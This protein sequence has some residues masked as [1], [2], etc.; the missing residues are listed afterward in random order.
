MK[1]HEIAVKFSDSIISGLI[2]SAKHMLWPLSVNRIRQSQ[3][4]LMNIFGGVNVWL[5]NY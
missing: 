4:I 2:N 5:I 1:G 3:R